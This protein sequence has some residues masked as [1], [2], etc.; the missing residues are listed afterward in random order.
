MN[1]NH[2]ISIILPVYNE[3][4]N[5]KR[6]IQ[7][8]EK[9]VRNQHEI[10]VVY[11]FEEDP[12]L[13]IVKD[14]IKN[15]S[16]IF[17]VKNN[18]GRGI[19][20]AIKTGFIYS[21]GDYIIV[22][23]SDQTDD[24]NTINA[25][26]KK[27]QEGYDIVGGTRYSKGGKRKD[28]ISL[29][30]LLSKLAGIATPYLLGIPITDLTNGFKMYRKSLINTIPIESKNG[31]AFSMELVIKAKHKNFLISEIPTFSNKRVY[32]KSKFK[33]IKWLPQYIYW[34]LWGIKKN[35]IN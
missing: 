18:L 25:M 34:Y 13:L 6:T 31:W 33:L 19:V 30:L 2:L 26:Y 32:G 5:I 11:D 20:N 12:S 29:K 17:L 7:A 1:N 15:N 24:P 16:N 14:L 10:L 9:K 8:I 28:N 27:I 3:E 23:S 22:M 35:F 4:K 21:K